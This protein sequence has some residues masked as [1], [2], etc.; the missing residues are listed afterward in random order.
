MSKTPRPDDNLRV[1]WFR[2]MLDMRKHEHSM[3]RVARETGIPRTTLLQWCAPDKPV[4]AKFEDALRVIALWCEVTMRPIGR[5]PWINR[6]EPYPQ[7]SQLSTV[8][9]SGTRQGA[10]AKMPPNQTQR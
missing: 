8:K 3:A 6:F 10:A 5:L 1:D 4:Q 9:L 7:L 2:V